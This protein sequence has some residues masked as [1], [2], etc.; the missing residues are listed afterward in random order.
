MKKIILDCDPGH[1]DMIA[2][3]LASTR[4]EIE[5][6]G[7]TT[8]AGNQTGDKTFENALKTLTLI[9]RKDIKVAR[10]FDKPILRDLVTAPKIHGIS[11]LDGAN[12]PIPQVEP[13]KIHAVDFIINTILNSNEKIYLVPTGPLTN[14]AISLIK[15]PKIKEKIEKIVLMGGAIFDS[16]IT[17]SA[18][19]NI[20]VDPEAA[21]IVFNSGIPLVMVGLDVTNKALLTFE[22]IDKIEK[23]NGK[24]SR[25]VG[26]LLKF[27]ANA[28]KE[29]FGFNGAPIHDALTV[30]YLVDESVLTLKDYY[31]DIETQGE[32]TRGRTVVDTYGVLKKKPNVSVAVNLDINKFKKM[33]FEMIEKLDIS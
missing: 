2:I 23:M 20:Y 6:L 15:E 22:D 18:E 13:L 3:M 12:L 8:V 26:P 24:V 1:D 31:V 14:I 9:N 7:I 30:A 4:N 16:N 33:I 21:K 19:F 25:V 27:F 11:G 17:P 10:G 32:L 5:L 28:N 29:F